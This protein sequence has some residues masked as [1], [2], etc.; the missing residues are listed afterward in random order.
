MHKKNFF[1]TFLI[2]LSKTIKNVIFIYIRMNF[3]KCE[4]KNKIFK[5]EKRSII[6]KNLM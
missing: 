6:N 4:A 2:K 5:I 3:C 1:S